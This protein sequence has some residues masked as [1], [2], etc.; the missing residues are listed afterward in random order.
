MAPQWFKR[1]DSIILTAE[2]FDEGAGDFS[3]GSILSLYDR[4]AI[5]TL[6]GVRRV[7]AT[8]L[9]KQIGCTKLGTGSVC[10]R[11]DVL[12]FLQRSKRSGVYQAE[13]ERQERLSERLEALRSHQ[14]ARSVILRPPDPQADIDSLPSG[15]QVTKTSLH[16]E[17]AGFNDFASKLLELGNIMASDYV[18]LQAL[19]GE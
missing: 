5:E 14:R 3:G 1:L 7:G 11:K 12:L 4:Q 17:F 13:A 10:L 6:F 9:M 2:G 15:V 8:N 16:M 19:M 18:R